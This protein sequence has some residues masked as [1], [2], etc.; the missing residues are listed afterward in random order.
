M[1]NLYMYNNVYFPEDNYFNTNEFPREWMEY[2]D[3]KASI[4]ERNM[5][6]E[7]LIPTYSPN[8]TQNELAKFFHISS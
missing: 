7:T 6:E 8:L 4:V 3:S 5:Q 1:M 2:F